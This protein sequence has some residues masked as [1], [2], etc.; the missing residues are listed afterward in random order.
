MSFPHFIARR[1]L[2]GQEGDKRLSRPIVIIAVLGIVIGMAVMILTVAITSGFQRTIR[3]KVSDI[4][5]HLVIT[6]IGQTDPKETPRVRM[7]DD[8]MATLRSLPGVGHVQVFATKPGIIETPQDIQG[9]IVKGIGAD[10]DRTTLGRYLVEGSDLDIGSVERKQEVVLSH[11]LARRLRIALNDTVTI[12]LV[13]GRDDIRPRRFA[14]RGIYET[15]IERI[16]HQLILVDIAHLQRFSGWGLQAEILAGEVEDGRYLTIEG[17]A[18]GGD[19]SYSYEWPGTDLHGKGPHRLE[20][21]HWHDQGSMKNAHLRTPKDTTFTLVVSDE[22]GT[23]PDTAIIHVIPDQVELVTHSLGTDLVVRHVRIERRGS[24]GSHARY[25]GGL[26]VFADR[27]N[28][29]PALNDAVYRV[30]PVNLRTESV[31]DRF[32][33]IFAWL[34]LLDTNVLVVIV[35]MVIVAIINMTSALLIIIL[36]RTRMIG[37]MKALGATNGTMRRIFLIDSAYLLGAGLL[38]GD[39]L[40]IG[41]C[42]VQQHFG[43]VHLPLESYYVDT[44]PVELSIWPLLALDLGTLAVCITA[45]VLPT[46]LVSRIAPARAIRFD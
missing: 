11:Y 9:V 20:L 23:I 18:F 41:L 17:Q 14:V 2:S 46:H 40:G 39:L 28:G 45:M 37:I 6:S 43:L 29:I 44:V 13:K 21:W 19:R 34:D 27:Q 8:L 30:L 38:L 36:E 12:Y 1:M 3:S 32:P 33:E 16:D 15:G 35:L 22:Q 5:A 10:H 7:D 42:L 24:G 31:T 26:E 25:I 4:T